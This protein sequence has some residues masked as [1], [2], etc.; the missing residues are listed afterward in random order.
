MSDIEARDRKAQRYISLCR[1][2]RQ[3][4]MERILAAAGS[5]LLFLALVL[6]W[7]L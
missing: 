5:T 1:N 6:G 4:R 3:A 2:R 7:L